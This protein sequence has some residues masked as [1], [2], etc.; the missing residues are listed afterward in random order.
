MYSGYDKTLSPEENKVI[1]KAARRKVQKE[2]MRKKALLTDRT[3][4]SFVCPNCET[5]L[6]IEIADLQRGIVITCTECDQE[7]VETKAEE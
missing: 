6:R 4:I 1:R 7:I 3:D 2:G 5:L